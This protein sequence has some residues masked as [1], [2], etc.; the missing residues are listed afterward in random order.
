MALTSWVSFSLILF[1]TC[2]SVREDAC[3]VAV[4]CIVQDVDP[5]G[6]EHLLLAREAGV[7]GADRVEA[8]VERK[9][10]G[11]FPAGRKRKRKFVSDEDIN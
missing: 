9:V 1:P 8:M 7:A 2:L 3:V 5:E 6:L 4:E 11:R 10:L